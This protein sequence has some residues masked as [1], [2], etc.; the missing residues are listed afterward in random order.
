M[1]DVHPQVSEIKEHVEN[2]REVVSSE[3]SWQ[4]IS[5]SDAQ[6]LLS[7]TVPRLVPALMVEFLLD[8]FTTLVGIRCLNQLNRKAYLCSGL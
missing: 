2:V 1:S 5:P 3:R 6:D 7:V 8:C 4:S